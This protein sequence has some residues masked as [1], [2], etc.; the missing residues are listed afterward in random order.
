MK[1]TIYEDPLTHRL[2]LI[3]LPTRFVDGDT[4][5][6]TDVDRWFGSRDEALAALS[7]LLN[8]DDR[9]AVLGP[10]DTKRH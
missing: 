3:A 5:P 2:A 1:Y 8:L 7:D 4:L 9:D 10:D 6:I